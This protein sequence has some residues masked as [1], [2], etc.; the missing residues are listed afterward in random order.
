MS[1]RWFGLPYKDGD[2]RVQFPGYGWLAIFV[3]PWV[4]GIYQIGVWL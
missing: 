4:I 3:I 1:S 2:R